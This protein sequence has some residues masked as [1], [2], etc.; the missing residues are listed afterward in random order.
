VA[1]GADG[2]DG[3]ADDDGLAYLHP[4]F[5]LEAAVEGGHLPG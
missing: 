4:G 2:A 5:G 3:L 1:G